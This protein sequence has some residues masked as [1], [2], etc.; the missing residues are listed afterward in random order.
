MSVLEGFLISSTLLSW[1]FGGLWSCVAYARLS[2]WGRQTVVA[3]EQG[4]QTVVA[5]EQ[6][7]QTV[8]ASEQAR[9]TA[10]ASEQARQTAVVSEQAQLASG[11]GHQEAEGQSSVACPLLTSSLL[12]DRWCPQ[13]RCEHMVE[14]EVV[15][16]KLPTH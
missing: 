10:L 9:Q 14:V 5:S 4:W 11:K 3:S 6:R 16:Q 13:A 15:V 12:P 1:R 2:Q 8:V 7:W